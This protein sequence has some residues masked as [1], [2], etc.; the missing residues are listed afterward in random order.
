MCGYWGTLVFLPNIVWSWHC[1]L[2]VDLLWLWRTL[3][4]LPNIVV[5][6]VVLFIGQLI[7]FS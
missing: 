7:M 3:V 1:G 4:F 2:V 5:L 6:R